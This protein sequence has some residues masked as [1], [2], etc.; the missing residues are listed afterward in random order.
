MKFKNV[1]K[2][3]LWLILSNKYIIVQQFSTEEVCVAS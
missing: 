3:L 1:V 2:P